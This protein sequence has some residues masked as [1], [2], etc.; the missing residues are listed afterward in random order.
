[1]FDPLRLAEDA[2][3][4]D[5]LSGGRLILGLGIGWRDEEFD[6]FGTAAGTRAARLEATIEVLR[7]SWGDGLTT[8]DGRQFRYP[9][10]GL[11]VTPKPV[12]G[13]ATPI[14][15]GAGAERAVRRAG[16]LADGY[17]GSGGSPRALT[18]R[19]GWIRE[20]AERVGRDPSTIEIA[21]QR[22]T[23]AWRDGDA[24]RRVADAA[25]YMSWKYEDMSGSR[26]SRTRRLPGPDDEPS[27]DVVRSRLI[28]GTPEEVADGVRA[29]APTLG[30]AG[31]YVFRTHFPGLDPAIQRDAVRILAEEVLPL[32]QD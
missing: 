4:V 17:L 11:N 5:L 1:M 12:R 10:P 27:P 32:L 8:G 20:E 6:G 9:D 28:V 24:W 22:M 19:A 16:R 21:L 29:Y 7:Q 14:W 15:I 25:R 3:T 30:E 26:G 2:A 31:S 13:P 18:E 23:F